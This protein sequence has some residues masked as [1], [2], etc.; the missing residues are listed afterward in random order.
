M[1]GRRP[2]RE[3]QFESGRVLHTHKVSTA[4]DYM[5]IRDRP[6]MRSPV[7]KPWWP[8]AIFGS[9]RSGRWLC[10]LNE[11]GRCSRRRRRGIAS[12]GEE[13]GG[14]LE[15]AFILRN[16]RSEFV[17]P[18]RANFCIWTLRSSSY[19]M[20]HVRF[21]TR[22]SQQLAAERV[23]GQ[24]RSDDPAA[25]QCEAWPFVARRSRMS[26]SVP[27]CRVL[28]FFQAR[29]VHNPLGRILQPKV[30]HGVYTL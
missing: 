24:A 7:S 5:V 8:A 29:K 14:V 13:A 15:L 25:A 6:R 4:M 22:S 16:Q 1:R 21:C 30:E 2:R 10:M 3:C 23:Q 26:R 9:C 18:R 27:R 20:E 17:P 19:S 11:S 12:F 28:V